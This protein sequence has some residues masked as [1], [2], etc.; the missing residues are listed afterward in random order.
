MY[1]GRERK[2]ELERERRTNVLSGF[3]IGQQSD[4]IHCQH[5]IIRGMR[6]SL[7]GCGFYIDSSKRH[8]EYAAGVCIV[9]SVGIGGEG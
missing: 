2:R 3:V 7:K 6:K 4:S 1:R 8:N 9:E 5:R